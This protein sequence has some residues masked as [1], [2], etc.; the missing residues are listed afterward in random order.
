M[1]ITHQKKKDKMK[2]I[3]YFIMAL[4]VS[5]PCAAGSAWDLTED[6][7]IQKSLNLLPYQAVLLSPF[8]EYQKN[9]AFTYLLKDKNNKKDYVFYQVII[10]ANAE[11]QYLIFST[12]EKCIQESPLSAAV[13]NVSGKN[14]QAK[15]VCT[16]VEDRQVVLYIIATEAG[17]EYVIDQFKNDDL[18][19]IR[20]NRRSIPFD[21]S[22]FNEAWE[23]AG[24]AAL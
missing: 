10:A 6:K 5:S 11:G 21:L 7:D 22:G 17:K 18:V 12:P 2:I 14:I 23:S 20:F 8:N 15:T 3:L 9:S 13:I 24:G 16:K 1:K 4:M 19:L